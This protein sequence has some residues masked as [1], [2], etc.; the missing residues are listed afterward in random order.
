V[1][2]NDPD[3]LAN[4]QTWPTEEEM[5]GSESITGAIDEGLPDAQVGTTPKTVRRIPKGMSEYQA[6]WIID[7]DDEEDNDEEGGGDNGSD[8]AMEDVEE[9]MVNMPLHAEGQEMESEK[10]NSVAFQDLDVEE[11]EKQ[12]VLLPRMIRPSFSF[13]ACQGS[14]RGAT[15]S[16]RRKTILHS[17][18]KLILPGRYLLASVSNAIVE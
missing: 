3:D 9:E 12:Y 16:E 14:R 17:Q 10:R 1:S 11:E 2:S 6:A 7:D 15:A 8:A 18:T 4:E 5:R 13:V